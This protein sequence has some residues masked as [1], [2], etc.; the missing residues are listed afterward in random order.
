MEKVQ[1]VSAD[2]WVYWYQG[3]EFAFWGTK[4]TP[5]KTAEVVADPGMSTW[6]I[7]FI[8]FKAGVPPLEA[9][10]PTL[11]VKCPQ[12]TPPMGDDR[13]TVTKERPFGLHTAPRVAS[14]AA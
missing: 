2:K 5:L 7:E 1:G 14:V 4:T 9:F 8:D 11:G 13:D 3:A 6:Q 12:S 10:A